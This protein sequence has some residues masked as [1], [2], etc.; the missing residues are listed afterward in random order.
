MELAQPSNRKPIIYGGFTWIELLMALVIMATGFLLALPSLQAS[1]ERNHMETRLGEIETI[2]RFARSQSLIQNQP[3]ALTPLPAAN[4]WAKGMILFTD[5][6]KHTYQPDSKIF[7][8]WRWRA[9]DL[10]I[11]WHGFYAKHYLIFADNL[12]ES[13]MNG[14]FLIKNK[15]Q[16]YKLI[17]NRLGRVRRTLIS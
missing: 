9:S 14:Y 4:D 10:Q 12:C 13:A 3:L 5:N 16:Q 1:Y 15:T 17:V 8:E 6:A 7:H 2:L 11:T